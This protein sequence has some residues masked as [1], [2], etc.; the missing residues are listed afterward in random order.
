MKSNSGNAYSD[1]LAFGIEREDALLTFLRC[2]SRPVC[3]PSRG[4]VI[5]RC[6]EIPISLIN[7]EKG[8][9]KA[10]ACDNACLRHLM[11]FMWTLATK[12]VAL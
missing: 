8:E 2:Q 7:I 5:I 1:A 12:P 11:T 6:C 10:Q 9:A 4:H 3:L